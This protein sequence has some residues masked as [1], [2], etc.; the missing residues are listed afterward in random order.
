MIS[1]VLA[2]DKVG[3]AKKLNSIDDGKGALSDLL[4]KDPGLVQ[5]P[6]EKWRAWVACGCSRACKPP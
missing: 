5:C 4:T 1:D 2:N 6:P 3:K